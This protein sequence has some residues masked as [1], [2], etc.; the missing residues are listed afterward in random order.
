MGDKLTREID[1]QTITLEFVDVGP[2][3]AEEWLGLNVNNRNTKKGN[4]SKITRAMELDEFR[5][6]GDPI[7]FDVKGQLIDGQHRLIGIRRSGTSQTLLVMRGF[8]E[9]AQLYVDQGSVRLAGDQIKIARVSE[10]STNDWASIARLAIRWD[11]EDLTTNIL[12]PSNPEIIAFCNEHLD[13]MGRAVI[14]ARGQYTRVKGRVPVAGATHF[15]AERIDAKLCA[16]FFRKLATGADLPVGDPVFALRDALLKRKS[17]DRM[18][19][20]EELALYVAAWNAKRA[21][22]VVQRLQQPRLGLRTEAFV[23]K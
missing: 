20:L 14:A 4:L 5:F 21:G 2:D 9:E 10:R 1:G 19:A 6:V 3:L 22:R 8:H 17:R 12:V 23:L 18:T 7:R 16:E 15:F 11:A 13:E